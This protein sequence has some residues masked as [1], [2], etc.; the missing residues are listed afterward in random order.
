MQRLG[1]PYI[2]RKTILLYRLKFF[3]SV[4]L[5]CLFSPFFLSLFLL[6]PPLYHIMYVMDLIRTFVFFST[7]KVS[8][9]SFLPSGLALLG[10]N[11]SEEAINAVKQVLESIRPKLNLHSQPS[12]IISLTTANQ[13]KQY[14]E[15]HSLQF[16]VLVVDGERIK[17]AYENLPALKVEYED[18]F[19]TAVERVGKIS[20]HF[21]IKK[22]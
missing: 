17:D 11:V 18:L 19:K 1:F 5:S 7:L 16:C 3:F 13:I 22:K 20:A 8:L 6:L 10:C 9:F 14:L 4:V 2:E 12:V 15:R 21:V